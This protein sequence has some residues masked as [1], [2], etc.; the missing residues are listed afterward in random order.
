MCCIAFHY[1]DD[2]ITVSSP[3]STQYGD[4]LSMMIETCSEMG[5]PVKR[6]KAWR[7]IFMYYLSRDWTRHIGYGARLPSGK[8][9]DLQKLLKV[10]RNRKAG[11]KREFLFLIGVLL[12]A[13]KVVRAGRSFLRRLIYRSTVEEQLDYYVRLNVPTKGDI[14]WCYHFWNGK[15]M[16]T[17]V[18]KLQATPKCC[19]HIWC[20]KLMGVWGMVRKGVVSVKVDKWGAGLLHYSER[21]VNRCW[22]GSGREEQ[23]WWDVITWQQY[24]SLIKGPV[25][26]NKQCCLAFNTAEH[27]L[28]IF[29]T[30]IP[31]IENVA[32]DALS[33]NK[34]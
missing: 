33:R 26:I 10:W 30:H 3:G 18:N 13:C 31:G 21:N 9:N 12:H 1:L 23:Y 2:F 29:A 11:F 19:H 32:A 27:Q 16:L 6:I 22:G 28:F 24:L 4:N 20:I 34:L 8:L 25:M 15:S 5:M 7:S 14:E 17:N